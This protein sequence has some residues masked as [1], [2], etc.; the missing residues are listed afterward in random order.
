MIMIIKVLLA[1]PAVLVISDTSDLIKVFFFR[2]LK[3]HPGWLHPPQNIFR[4]ELDF[5]SRFPPNILS[6]NKDMSGKDL[7]TLI[8]CIYGNL[9]GM[10]I[11]LFHRQ[12]SIYMRRSFP[13]AETHL[14]IS[15]R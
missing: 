9:E 15:S 4:R 1:I 14:I 2:S 12:E 5:H 11:S 10:F 13:M 6:I 3:K 7:L 8:S